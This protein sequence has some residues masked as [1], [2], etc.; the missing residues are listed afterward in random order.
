MCSSGSVTPSGVPFWIYCNPGAAPAGS[1][2]RFVV[3]ALPGRRLTPGYCSYA[4]PGLK[5]SLA[6]TRTLT[7]T[8]AFVTY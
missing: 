5:A 3:Y 2:V 6:T 8:L 4:P 7:N 1:Y